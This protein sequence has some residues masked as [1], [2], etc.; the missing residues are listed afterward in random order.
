MSSLIQTLVRLEAALP[1]LLIA[2]IVLTLNVAWTIILQLFDLQFQAIA[3]LPLLDLQNTRG[4]RSAHE[5]LALVAG[6]SLEARSFYWV[7]FILDTIVP[8]LAF[9][10]FALLWAALLRRIS[11][12]AYAWLQ[13]TPLLLIP[14]GVG[15]FD[16][17]ENLAFLAAMHQPTAPIALPVMQLGIAFVW[18]KAA[19]LFATFGLTP[20]L[21]IALPIAAL[22]GR[23]SQAPRRAA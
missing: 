11:P 17:F 6:Y 22:R 7:F 9:G 5:A 1:P 13:R 14:L 21:L 16:S 19:C 23:R 10:S 12:A 18:M 15:L 8:L 2:A 20:A 4:I 3:G